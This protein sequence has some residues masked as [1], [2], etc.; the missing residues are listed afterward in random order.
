MFSSVSRR[1]CGDREDERY[2]FRMIMSSPDSRKNETAFFILTVKYLDSMKEKFSY[3]NHR[4]MRT[5][6]AQLYALGILERNP[7]LKRAIGISCEPPDQKS[8]T[9]E[10][11]VYAEQIE[12]TDE[13]RREIR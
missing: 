7:N 2:V 4:L 12:W 11:M 8:F 3:E 10:D 13:E 5:S 6:C 9:S 1:G